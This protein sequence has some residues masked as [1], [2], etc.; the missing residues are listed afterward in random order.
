MLWNL[1]IAAR[2]LT[3]IGTTVL[4][5]ALL[6]AC[7][8]LDLAVFLFAEASQTH[9]AGGLVPSLQDFIVGRRAE[10]TR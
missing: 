8:G 9:C 6:A 1:P 2:P 10:A 5:M 4:M 3:A 7:G